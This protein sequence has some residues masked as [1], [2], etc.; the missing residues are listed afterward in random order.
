MGKYTPLIWVLVNQ[1]TEGIRLE[2]ICS[3]ILLYIVLHV[4]WIFRMVPY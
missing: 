2:I 1:V 3:V 4:F